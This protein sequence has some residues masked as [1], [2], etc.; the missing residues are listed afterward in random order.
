M[1]ESV[2][3]HFGLTEADRL[4]LGWESGI[5]ALSPTQILRIPHPGPGVEGQVRNRAEFTSGLP[6]LP[7]EVP[8][9]RE[10]RYVDGVLI[11]VEDRISG[12]PLDAILPNL[13]GATR[14]RA[15]AAYLDTTDAM[16]TIKVE[17]D[18]GDLLLPEPLRCPHWGDYLARRLDGFADDAVLAAKVP[19]YGEKV[20]RI[21]AQLMAL[22]D[23][24]KCLVHGDIWPPNIMMDAEFRV[25][26]LLDFSFTTRVG[27][28]VM[29]LAGAVHFNRISNPQADGDFAYLMGLIEARHG[30]GLQGRIALYAVWFAFSFAYD[31]DH[32]VIFPWCLDMI[33][34]Y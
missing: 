16:R 10:I 8:R 29:D 30:A 1:Y 4:G 33:R 11:A 34:A 7:F 19:G 21:R 5:F 6:D 28:W 3:Q 9:V 17:G 27:D 25:T 26:G 2:L 13:E 32:K 18:Y 22:P 14:H 20:A 15:L 24:E 12:R 31:H 23:P